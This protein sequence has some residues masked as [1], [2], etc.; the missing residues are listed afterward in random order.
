MDWGGAEPP[1][2]AWTWWTPES[3]ELVTQWRTTPVAYDWNGDQHCDLV[4]LDTEGFLALYERV[5]I[6]GQWKLTPGRRIFMTDSANNFDAGNRP[7]TEAEGPL[8]LNARERGGS[9][10]RKL[11]LG[12]WDGDGQIDLLVNS[13]NADWFAGRPL[14]NGQW[15]FE[16][17]DSIS[18]EPIS[19][20]TTSPTVVDFDGDGRLEAVI[21]AE[22]GFLYFV[23]APSR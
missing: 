19:G 8:R 18:S 7:T 2:P 22:D 1:K 3:D 9:G 10:R 13:M 20:H 5:E 6:D 11:C 21:G 12:D 23:P 15:Q 17:R 16:L 14:E 4:M